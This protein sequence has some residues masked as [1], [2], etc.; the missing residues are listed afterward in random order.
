[1]KFLPDGPGRVLG[2]TAAGFEVFYDPH[3]TQVA[4]AAG[5]GRWRRI[6]VGSAYFFLPAGMRHAVLLHEAGH[7]RSHH[8]LQRIAWLPLCWTAR[9]RAHAAAH[10]LE[11]DAF[12][13]EQGYGADLLSFVQRFDR[14]G[15]FYPD[16]KD[17]CAAL[18]KCLRETGH[19][20]A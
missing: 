13:A 9:A 5:I 3:T 18:Q 17:R 10:E 14:G 4:H 11:A 7:L 12:V 1:M 6:I 19:A 20:A 15:E 8:L 16:V 2:L